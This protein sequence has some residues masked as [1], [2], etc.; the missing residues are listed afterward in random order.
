VRDE[1][2]NRRLEVP[3]HVVGQHGRIPFQG[4]SYEPNVGF[5]RWRHPLRL[6]PIRCSPRS[7]VEQEGRQPGSQ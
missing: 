1:F 4:P 6:A 7:R 3:H 2:A 5:L